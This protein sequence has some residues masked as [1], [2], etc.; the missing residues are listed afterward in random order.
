MFSSQLVVFSAQLSQDDSILPFLFACKLQ[1]VLRPEERASNHGD[2]TKIALAAIMRYFCKF[3]P[4]Q[5]ACKLNVV[6]RP[7][8]NI[9]IYTT[10]Q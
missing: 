5:F 2:W 1:L 4:S 10:R 9:Y 6:S 7:L 8:K 3:L